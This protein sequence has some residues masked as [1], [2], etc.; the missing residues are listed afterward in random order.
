MAMMHLSLTIFERG[1][2][3]MSIKRL[4][5][6]LLA[7]TISVSVMQPLS[8]TKVYAATL[9]TDVPS[10]AEES[11]NYLAKEGIL[12]G[13]PDGTFRPNNPITIEAFVKIT[14]GALGHT[15]LPSN[16]GHWADPYME[17]AKELGLFKDET[18]STSDNHFFESHFN[19]NRTRNISRQEVSFIMRQAE[20]IKENGNIDY[21]ES[22]RFIKSLIGDFDDIDDVY[23]KYVVDAYGLGLI[24]G[25]GHNKFDPKGLVTR[26][27][28]AVLIYRLLHENKRVRVP[29]GSMSFY[30]NGKEITT[31]TS[32]D[33]NVDSEIR[34]YGLCRN[35][36][37]ITLQID[38]PDGTIEYMQKD[39][40]SYTFY[41]TPK[42]Q[43]IYKFTLLARNTKSSSTAGTQLGKSNIVTV[44]VE[45]P[46]IYIPGLGSIKIDT[47]ILGTSK[48]TGYFKG[49]DNPTIREILSRIP[50]G[51]KNTFKPNAEYSQGFRFEWR[52][53]SGHNWR[54]WGHE[55]ST[56]APSGSNSSKGWTYR[57]EG[58]SGFRDGGKWYLTKDDG[59]VKSNVGNEKS[60]MYNEK[61]WDESHMPMQTPSDKDDDKNNPSGG[62]GGEKITASETNPGADLVDILERAKHI[63]GELIQ[64]MTLWELGDEITLM[65]DDLT[66][67]TIVLKSGII[68]PYSTTNPALLAFYPN[69]PPLPTVPV[70]LPSFP[71]IP[72]P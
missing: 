42:Q 55:A 33:G 38:K 44:N 8:N 9:F 58:S 54:V 61:L 15:N 21:E 26:A 18:A 48:S 36:H 69:L 62:S 46:I 13:Y 34:F 43:G 37:H 56:K 17:K 53:A 71:A 25:V 22:E 3:L 31:N 63:K 12:N 51:I 11:V 68:Y 4:I 2:I 57:V 30:V 20:K 27:Q 65:H 35:A 52:D 45:A 60:P 70:L 64:V 66:I 49:L 41:Y 16:G 28:A 14:L 29:L 19:G 7:I 72:I 1:T 5:S 6:M 59:W 50:S 47:E 23:K 40:D 10:W 67:N 32:I 39:N 24:N